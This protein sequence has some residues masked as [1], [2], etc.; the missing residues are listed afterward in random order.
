MS[1]M[2]CSLCNVAPRSI[3]CGSIC[4]KCRSEKQRKRYYANKVEILRRQKIY[5][6]NN[7]KIIYD[8]NRERYKRTAQKYPLMHAFH[9]ARFRAKKR[10]IPF[11][12]IYSDLPAPPDVCPI[13]GVKLIYNS[14]KRNNAS[15]SI[16]RVI[17]SLGYIPG[18]IAI[19]S[20]RANAI[21]H[22]ATVEELEMVVAFIKHHTA[23]AD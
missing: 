10:R 15:P 17:P 14:G 23:N 1:N 3:N 7:K 6:T 9:Q 8:K 4:A 20:F 19:I 11:S 12:M 16:D 18:N 21:K 13:L 22:N 2:I 5:F